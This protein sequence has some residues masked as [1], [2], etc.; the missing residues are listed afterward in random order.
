MQMSQNPGGVSS[1]PLAKDRAWQSVREE[2]GSG[3]HMAMACGA[4]LRR[5]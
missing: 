4:P 5:Q 1:T 3:I 2:L